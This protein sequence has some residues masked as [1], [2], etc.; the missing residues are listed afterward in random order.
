MEPDFESDQEDEL[1][2]S[3]EGE[4]AYAFRDNEDSYQHER[5]KHDCSF[6]T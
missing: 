1:S 5:L 3:H 4:E 2:E 6:C